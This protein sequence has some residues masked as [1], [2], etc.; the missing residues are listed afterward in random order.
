MEN[1][2]QN[3]TRKL[4]VI[5]NNHYSYYLKNNYQHQKK[6]NSVDN[7]KPYYKSNYNFFDSNKN[8][9]YKANTATTNNFLKI[10]YTN[11]DEINSFQ[12][13]ITTT[14][15]NKNK[16]ISYFFN[17]D[18][19]KI[20]SITSSLYDI[21]KTPNKNIYENNFNNLFKNSQ[22]QNKNLIDNN[23]NNIFNLKTN[24]QNY[25]LNKDLKTNSNISNNAIN[26]NKIS[27][28]NTLSQ[29]NVS[30][31]LT[32]SNFR[33]KSQ[34]PYSFQKITP[35]NNNLNKTRQAGESVTIIVNHNIRKRKCPLCHKEIDKNRINFHMN[36]HPSKIFDW[37][38]LGC[39][40]NACNKEEIK[41]LK[42]NY[43]L[44]CAFECMESFSN[45]IKYCH[46]K[47]SD[48]PSFRIIPFFE[49]AT[50]FI[51]QA[52]K[53]GGVI[54]VH[55]QLGISRSTSCVIAYMIKYMGYT[56]MSALDFIRKK[57]PQVMPNF[58]FIQ[59]LMNYEKSNLG[60]GMKSDDEKEIEKNNN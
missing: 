32:T 49:R 4:P 41:D 36:T 3:R 30:I 55:C 29:K 28:N 46:L 47:L 6:L 53:S 16:P 22:S 11:K 54:L 43:V 24:S 19:K 23:T 13:N 52:H 9:Y 45:N 8:N 50:S 18:K 2:F 33:N 10:A 57:R 15:Y 37:L 31:N 21:K 25:S 35:N 17:S 12:N 42:I 1:T 48:M 39:Y 5:G 20:P 56:A 26:T 40:R 34:K 38:F 58:G 44:N 59:Q 14:Y 51:N 60:K 7:K 27:N